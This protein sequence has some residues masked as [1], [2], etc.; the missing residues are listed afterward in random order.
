MRS[1]RSISFI[2]CVALIS[3]VF[4]MVGC[5]SK[6]EETPIVNPIQITITIDYPERAEQE[7]ITEQPFNIEEDSSVLEA[8]QL[9]CNVNDM[10]INIETT[11]GTVVGINGL[12]NGDLFTNRTWQFKINGRL[13]DES[14]GKVILEDGDS[15]EWVYRK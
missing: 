11:K 3:A 7:D 5:D 14:A 2:L 4:L 13:A 8:I 10:E 9:Y 6:E 15:L 1:K 12:N